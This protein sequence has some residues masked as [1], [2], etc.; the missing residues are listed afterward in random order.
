MAVE[1]V[2]TVDETVPIVVES[3]VANLGSTES[4]P[5][6]VRIGAVDEAIAVV[7]GAV[8]ADFSSHGDEIESQVAGSTNSRGTPVTDSKVALNSG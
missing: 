7:I 1:Y 4:D 3:I 5:D 8:I 2:E 6:A